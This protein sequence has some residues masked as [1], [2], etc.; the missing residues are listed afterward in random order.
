ML[1]AACSYMPNSGPSAGSVRNEAGAPSRGYV[2]KKGGDGYVLLEVSPANNSTAA[3]NYFLVNLTPT[4]LQRLD[5]VPPPTLADSFGD[6]EPAPHLD[7][8]SGDLVSVSIWEAGQGSL[9]SGQ[10]MSQQP[11]T[12]ATAPVATGSHSITLPT[13]IVDNDGAVNIPFAGPVKIAG[14][15]AADAS[16]VIAD[17]LSRK[18]IQ[19][20]AL[21]TV[22]AN[23]SNFVTV[24]G[25][26]TRPGRI[27]LDFNGS[28][29][30]DALALA[31]GTTAEAH[32]CVLQLTRDGKSTR[33]RLSSVYAE[34]AQ[35]IFLRSRDLLFVIREP[36][37]VAVLGAT[38]KNAQVP[39]DTE[40]LSLAEA[41]GKAGGLVD[42]Q[43]DP[44]GVFIVRYEP[45]PVLLA[46]GLKMEQGDLPEFAPVVYQADLQDP[47]TLLLMQSFQMRD[48]DLVFI[49][50]SQ[51]VQLGKLVKILRD[52]SLIFQNRLFDT[53]D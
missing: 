5:T 11:A 6:A 38:P 22:I 8:G 25:D 40:H 36:E 14:Q 35:N 49:A 37:T 27:P 53:N 23:G 34:P 19:P 7:I 18:A 21:V 52:T 4:V 24:T 29:V 3:N 45:T 39:F 17:T 2:L 30:L 16:R 47:A 32:D 51:S 42:I 20:Q 15:T 26:V 10:D 9:F 41:I 48:K 12:G 31:G 46:L 28:R 43:A 33:L 13:Q 50:T 1:L 44:A